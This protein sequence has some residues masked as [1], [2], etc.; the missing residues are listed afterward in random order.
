MLLDV[1]DQSLEIDICEL[2]HHKFFLFSVNKAQ[3]P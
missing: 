2:V 1:D 3:G